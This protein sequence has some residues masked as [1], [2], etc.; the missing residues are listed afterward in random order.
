[1]QRSQV[2]RYVGN[3]FW[4]FSE[5]GVQ[6]TLAFI[7]NLYMARYLGPS[8]FGLLSYA[9]SLVA[10][11]STFS[12]LGV[13]VILVRELVRQPREAARWMGTAFILKLAAST[14]LAVLLAVFQ[15]VFGRNPLLNQMMI[16]IAIGLIGLSWIVVEDYFQS[17]V[18]ARY[19]AQAKMTSLFFSAAAKI[20]LILLRAPLI[21][22][23]AVVLME[24]AVLAAALWYNY[25]KQ[26]LERFFPRFDA[27]LARRLMTDAWPMLLTN[28]AVAVYLKV[29]QILLKQM[30][31]ATAVG[32]YAAAVR[33]SEAVYFIPFALTNTF[34][35]AIITAKEYGEMIYQERLQ[36]FYDL[37]IWLGLVLA[38]FMALVV[39]H[40]V[41][42]LYGQAYAPAVT[43]LKLHGWSLLFVFM[44]NAGSR[45]F[46]AENRQIPLLI[47][48]A[49]GAISNIAL[50]IWLIPV[51]G[52]R[53]AALA[54][55]ISYGIAGF[56]ASA[57]FPAAWPNFVMI[58][59]SFNPI[60]AVRR[61]R[62]LLKWH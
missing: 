41:I 5:R 3:T 52:I 31:G 21:A 51:M 26:N 29:D 58:L 13:D 15:T 60:Q 62:D 11:L 7:A 17:K 28:L 24:N 30:A 36:R 43:V 42:L 45:W 12:A 4:L 40:F 57:C 33:I 46:L 47:I 55:V 22:F 19:S 56:A 49:A 32:H 6:L 18:A 25:H 39:P 34:Y 20:V 35:P 8:R 9:I 48:N 38:L 54:T 1:M 50:N 37:M 53:G 59:R 44:A 16:V 27:A 23:A 14:L 10:L 61:N 2:K